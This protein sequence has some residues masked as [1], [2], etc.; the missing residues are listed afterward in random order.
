MGLQV[1]LVGRLRPELGLTGYHEGVPVVDLRHPDAVQD[2]VARLGAERGA[3][4]VVCAAADAAEV[5]HQ[6]ALLAVALPHVTTVLEVVPGTPLAVSAAAS[7]ASDRSG[8]SDTAQQ[9]AI[10]DLLRDRLWSAVWLPKVARLSVPQPSVLQHARSWLPGAGFLAVAAPVPAVLAAPKPEALGQAQLPRGGTL[11]VADQGA[12]EWVVPAMVEALAPAARVD[13]QSWRDA[14]DA[15]GVG[16]CTE[17]VVV[18]ADLGQLDN[19]HPTHVTECD[20]CGRRHPRQ[21]CPFCRMAAPATAHDL[22][23][24]ES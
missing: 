14:R 2:T 1:A 8:V 23:G 18:P 4:I 16:G 5:R 21:A 6:L 13:V 20:G 3:V 15:Y 12:P 7:F 19:H 11:L 9:L 17:F 24:A 10:L 22:A